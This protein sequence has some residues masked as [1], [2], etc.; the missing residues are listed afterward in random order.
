VE[1]HQ[2]EDLAKFGY[3]LDMKESFCILSNCW[4]QVGFF[5]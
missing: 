2:W 3:R 4:K 5:F 1:N